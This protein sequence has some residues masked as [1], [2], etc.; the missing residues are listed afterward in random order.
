MNVTLSQMSSLN[1]S[2]LKKFVDDNNKFEN[3]IK[4]SKWVEDTEGKGEIARYSFSH[5]VFKRLVLQTRKDQGLFGEGLNSPHG[6]VHNIFLVYP[7]F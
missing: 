3:N 2:K 6:F 7:Y 4:L 1:S 5:S